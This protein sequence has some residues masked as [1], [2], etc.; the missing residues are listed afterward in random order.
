M[1][2]LVSI[3]ITCYN[4][5]QF[6]GEALD[7]VSTQ[8]Y[9]NIEIIVVDDGSPDNTSDV[10]T[11]YTSAMPNLRYIRQE[12]QG[13]SIARNN[14]IHAANGQY[15]MSLDAD[16]TISPTY[17]EKCANYLMNHSDV[18]LVYTIADTF[19]IQNGKWD[20][21]PYTHEALLWTNMVHYC[22]MFRREDFLLSTGYNP[23]MVKGFEDWDFWLSFLLPSDRVHCIEE[24]LFHWRI[25]EYSRSTDADNNMQTLLRQIYHNHEELYQPYLQDIV[26]FHEMWGHNEWLYHRADLVRHSHAYR[27][28]KFILKPLTWIRHKT[29]Y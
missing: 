25:L 12:N 26:F 21:P 6:L 15:I 1:T 17:V 24:R 18:K 7:S 4:K 29:K 14:G 28:G 20:L 10:V 23:N 19:G 16:D 11:S 27:I 8:T 9:P 13:V 5:A 22:A 2:P 3:I